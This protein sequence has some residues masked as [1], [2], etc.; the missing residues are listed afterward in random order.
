MYTCTVLFRS[1][2]FFFSGS[3]LLSVCVQVRAH[4]H[5]WAVSA[6]VKNFVVKRAKKNVSACDESD[7]R[8]PL[9]V[10]CFFK[11]QKKKQHALLCRVSGCRVLVAGVKKESCVCVCVCVCVEKKRCR[12]GS[13]GKEREFCN[14]I[15]KVCV[16]LLQ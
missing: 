12:E 3:L 16:H 5:V 11:K 1:G 6:G 8:G 2:G 9:S 14:G 13:L 7:G 4:D 10:L 15:L